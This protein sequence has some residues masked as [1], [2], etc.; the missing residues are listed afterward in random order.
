[1][2]GEE[3]NKGKSSKKSASKKAASKKVTS[4][5]TAKSTT[6]SQSKLPSSSDMKEFS[7]RFNS[8][9]WSQITDNQTFLDNFGYD[10]K[11]MRAMAEKI[12]A[13]KDV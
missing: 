4:K 10:I 7:E 12:L 1:M 5:K 6:K 11:E 8:D 9:E 3:E 13:G 2:A